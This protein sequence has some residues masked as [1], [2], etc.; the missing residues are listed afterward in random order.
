MQTGPTS[1]SKSAVTL[2]LSLISVLVVLTIATAFRHTW[3]EDRQSLDRQTADWTRELQFDLSH[4]LGREIQGLQQSLRIIGFQPALKQA[5]AATDTARLQNDWMDVFERLRAE[6]QIT[7]FYFSGPDRICVLRLHR[8]EQKGDRIDRLSMLEAERTG[9]TAWGLE[10]GKTGKFTLR[11]VQ[12][13]HEGDRLLGYVELGKEIEPLLNALRPSNERSNRFVVLLPKERIDRATWES[14]MRTR[15]LTDDWDALPRHVVAYGEPGL[16]LELLKPLLSRSD[17]DAGR[18]ETEVDGRI[19]HLQHE[20]LR[21]P[22]GEQPLDLVVF[23]DLTDSLDALKHRTV[24]MVLAT[25]SVVAMM[26]VFSIWVMQRF[27]RKIEHQETSLLSEN[28]KNQAL[29]RN[30]SD[31]IHILDYQGRIFEVSASF[32]EMLGY[33]RDELIGQPVAF[34]DAQFSKDEIADV[35]GRQM[36]SP[37]RVQFETRHRRKD[38]SIFD[39]EVSGYPVQI[40]NERYLFNSSRD[41]TDRKRAEASLKESEQ[42]FRQLFEHSPDPVWIID[43]HRFVECNQAAV[44]ML[45]FPDEAALKNIHPAEISP[46]FQPD[47]EASF[48]KAERMM[49]LAQDEGLHRFEWVHRRRD[50]SEFFA[51]VTLSNIVLQERSVLYVVWRDISE[52]KQAE[53]ELRQ[54]EEK[55]RIILD[56]VEAYIYLKD[57]EGK[58]LFANAAVRRLWKAEMEDIVGYGDEKFFDAE[59]AAHIR[60]VD[61]Q[62]LADGK[63]HR[64]EETNTVAE[65]GL[66]FTYWS[67]KLPLRREDGSIY[68]LCGI[69]TDITDRKQAEDRLFKSQQALNEAQHIAKVGSW[70]LDI[71]DNRLNWSDEIFRIFEID[72]ALFGAS[73]QAFLDAIHPDDREAVNQAYTASLQTRQLYSIRHRLRMADGRIKHVHE[74]CRT[75]FDAFGSPLRSIGTVQDVTEEVVAEAALHDARNLLQAVIDHVPIRIFW[76]DRDSNYLGCNP[77]FAVD[78]GCSQPADLIGKDDFQMG[79]SNQAAMYR[80]DDRKVI[81]SG[82]PRIGYEEPQTTPDGRTIWLRTSKVPLRNQN[83]EIIGVLGLYEDITAEKQKDEELARY[84]DHLKMLVQARTAQLGD[85]QAR[86]QRLVDDMGEEFLVFSFTPNNI[87]TYVSKSMDAIFGQPKE[88]MQGQSWTAGIKWLRQDLEETSQMLQDMLLGK[89]DAI[90]TEM[91]FVHPDGGIRTIFQ[92]CHA[93]RNG[94]GAVVSVDGVLTD[95]TQRKRTETELLDAKLSAEAANRAKSAFL[96]NMSHEIRTPMNG[97][98]GLLEVLS[99]SPLPAE[100]H[101]MVGTIRQSARS[102]L[103]I[104]DDILDFSKIEAGKLSIEETEISLEQELDSLIA[105]IDRLALDKQVDLSLFFEPGIPKRVMG[106]GLRV[107]QILTNLVGNAVKFCSGQARV[108]HVHVRAE[109]GPC[110]NG[111]V[112]VAFTIEDNGIGMDDGTVA[113]LFRPFE[114]A[115]NSTTR[116]FGGTGLG[117]SISRSLTSMMGGEISVQSEAGNGTTFTVSLPFELASEC[118]NRTSPYDLSGLDCVVATRETRYGADLEHYLAHAGAQVHS[119]ADIDAAWNFI[120]RENLDGPVCMIVMEEPGARSA[121]EVVSR[122]RAKQPDPEVCLV[123]IAYLSVER[124]RRRR[125]RRLSDK[126]V[127]IDREALTRRRFLEAV[128]AAAGRAAIRQES[129]HDDDVAA[130]SS[131]GLT[132]LV[133][134]DND[135]NRD[136]IRRQLEILGY[137]ADLAED[138]LRAFQAWEAGRYDLL[139]TDLHM[140]NKDGYELTA[141]IRDAESRFNLN[142]MP[143]VAL[144]ANA[145][146]GEEERCLDAGMDAYLSKPIEL[147]RLKSVLDRWLPSSDATRPAGAEETSPEP[148]VSSTE[149]PV[150]D[151]T[152]LAS[153]VGN[154]PAIQRRLQAK[155]LANVEQQM[156]ELQAAGEASDVRTIAQIAH[157]L[158]SAARSVGA[159]QLGELCEL[160]EQAGRAGDLQTIHRLLAQFGQA[161]KAATKAIDAWLGR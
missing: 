122:L 115:D 129:G 142:R 53:L 87:L 66:S 114:Q 154:N 158:K 106:D 48:S 74:Q 2:L 60:R 69:S 59:T 54:S 35:V 34:W 65:S 73:Y 91:R 25:L 144:T 44:G 131:A 132:I 136:V 101:K 61:R 75:D 9:K 71:P 67:V 33:S 16:P 157:A 109:L 3:Q 113:R 155:F 20:F 127:Q 159:L 151:P 118:P 111:H 133:A 24:V 104:I 110:E 105:L 80:A 152:M 38:G 84:R 70:E 139:L 97:V 102:L 29:L 76:K 117:L 55:L 140:P 96:A 147:A 30:A 11:V 82:L 90:R 98:I 8:L 51:E 112:W 19:L 124:G 78:A 14:G 13:V 148:A 126:V 120:G 32:C 116:K 23:D 134:E 93:V 138:G 7:H 43:G 6:N 88:K 64:M 130:A 103:G 94:A 153:L 92:T 137:R 81:E 18:I 56:S 150:F 22:N 68:A 17:L 149:T 141:L 95:I 145:M 77:A 49:N 28:T 10:M 99:R 121:Q 27:F 37:T 83:E 107:R 5:L 72:P 125:V 57:T 160:L 15:G 161:Q 135:I 123:A 21:L 40:G 12:P 143:I 58:Y 100:E 62:V 47:G 39:V 89:S 85:V 156:R 1:L 41:I 108:G 86:Y 36:K 26:L 31:G 46:E 128:A 4:L 42:R 146:K 119:H 79:W 50:G 52:R 45:G 63:T